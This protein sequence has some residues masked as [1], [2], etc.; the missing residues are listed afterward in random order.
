MV[1]GHSF[2]KNK[3]VKIEG[4]TVNVYLGL[5]DLERAFAQKIILDIKFLLKNED[6]CRDD[7]KN[8]VC[9]DELVGR[10]NSFLFNKQFNTVEYLVEE[11]YFFLRNC[12]KSMLDLEIAIKKL[13]PPLNGGTEVSLVKVKMGVQ[14]G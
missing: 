14:N 7:L 13:N 8:L 2:E 6:S 1:A 5:T 11:V 9:Y 3:K 12:Y 4:V 10:L